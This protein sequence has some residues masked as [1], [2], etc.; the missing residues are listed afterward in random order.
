MRPLVRSQ[1]SSVS[2]GQDLLPADVRPVIFVANHA[3]HVDTPLLLLALPDAYRRRTAV[4]A[5]AD[6]FFDTW[7]RAAASGLAFNTF[8]VERH[9]GTVSDIP[10]TLLRTGWSILVYPE[11]TRSPDGWM[12]RFRMGAA[13]L[14]VENGVPVVPVA[15]RG[16]FAA[17]ARGTSW[18]R[19]GRP[20]VRLRFG[21]PLYPGPGETVRQFAPRV[22]KGVAA[23][24]DEDADTWWAARRRAAAGTTPDMTGPKGAAGWRRRWD[25]VETPTRRLNRLQAWQRGGVSR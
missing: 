23:L 20:L 22:Q 5:A 3:S 11:G 7:W 12:H 4:A 15:I 19:P 25:Q 18:P 17:M 2:A 21:A 16:S 24:I 6:Y 8:P 1:L 9:A 10:G 13:W 14:A